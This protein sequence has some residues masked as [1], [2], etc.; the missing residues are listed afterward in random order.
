MKRP[1]TVWIAQIFLVLFFLAFLFG[2]CLGLVEEFNSMSRNATPFPVMMFSLAVGLLVITFFAAIIF[3]AFWGLQ[4]Q[5]PYGKWLTLPLLT[6][7]LAV[8]LHSQVSDFLN[9]SD[10]K[11]R[12]LSYAVGYVFGAGVIDMLLLT[13]ILRLGFAKQE[14]AFFSEVADKGESAV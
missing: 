3:L 8:T 11:L 7:L 12:E 1:L 13:V 2:G 5:K 4:K 10:T 9:G 14:R 6:L